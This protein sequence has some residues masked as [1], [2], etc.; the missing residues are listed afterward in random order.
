[1]SGQIRPVRWGSDFLLAD[2][3][4]KARFKEVRLATFLFVGTKFINLERVDS[5]ELMTLAP[6][7]SVSDVVINFSGGGKQEFGG[8]DALQVLAWLHAHKAKG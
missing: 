2:R 6:D 5:V 3:A 4:G 8:K 7:G 1:M